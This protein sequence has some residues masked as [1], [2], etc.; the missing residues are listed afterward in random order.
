M[1]R[2][3]WMALCMI[4]AGCA[5]TGDRVILGPEV[6]GPYGWRD[7]CVRYP[8]DPDCRGQALK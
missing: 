4:L 5:T 7:Y 8:D 3:S 2:Y 6:Y 1:V